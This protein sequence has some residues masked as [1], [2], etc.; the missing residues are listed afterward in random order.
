MNRTLA[1][2]L[3]ATLATIGAAGLVAGCADRSPGNTPK[4]PSAAQMTMP[5][6]TVMNAAD[7][8]AGATNGR[9]SHATAMICN[10]ETHAAIAQVLRLPGPPASTATWAD[11]LY[12]CTYRLPIGTLVVTVKQSRTDAAGRRYFAASRARLAPTETLYGLG[13]ASYGNR[14][15]VVVLRK[16]NDTLT[17]DATRLPARFG[18][19]DNK[20][21][22]FAYEIASDILG[23]WTGD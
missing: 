22:D 6:G 14:A 19:Q 13:S 8:G 16:D 10:A 3:S 17:V 21:Y 18:A 15:G 7:M 20:R 2:A 23:C 1:I 4:A 9:P 11:D 5:D 12:T